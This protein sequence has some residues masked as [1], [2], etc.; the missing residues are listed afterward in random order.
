MGA[1]PKPKPKKFVCCLSPIVLDI[2]AER[3]GGRGKW[4]KYGRTTENGGAGRERG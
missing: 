2:R 3:G 1:Y 4:Q